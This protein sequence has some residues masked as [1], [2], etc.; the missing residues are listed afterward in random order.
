[1]HSI[2]LLCHISPEL[3][4]FYLFFPESEPWH[5]WEPS[6]LMARGHTKQK[7]LYM[8]QFCTPLVLFIENSLIC[9]GGQAPTVALGA[10]VTEN[11]R[12]WGLYHLVG[13]FVYVL[14]WM[15]HSLKAPSDGIQH[16]SPVETEWLQMLLRAALGKRFRWEL[17]FFYSNQ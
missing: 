12:A 8:Q 5:V 14:C 17:R 15:K 1:M 10:S 6:V 16:L 13:P 11:G 4:V 2:Y 7:F 9:V 3:F